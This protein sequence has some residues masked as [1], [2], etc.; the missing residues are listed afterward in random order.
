MSEKEM[1]LESINKLENNVT[2][3]EMLYEIYVQYEVKLGLKD[4][5]EG[6][7][8]SEKELLKQMRDW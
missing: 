3:E 8:I 4:I 2:I 1:V 7:V 6:R 5:E